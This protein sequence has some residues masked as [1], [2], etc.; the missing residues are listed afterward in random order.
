[1]IPYLFNPENDALDCILNHLYSKSLSDVIKK[2]LE[3]EEANFTE[4]LSAEIKKR[5]RIVIGK[6]VNKL[7]SK[8]DDEEC[9][10]ATSILTELVETNDYFSILKQKPTIQR[11]SELAFDI[12]EG[13]S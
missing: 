9:F 6:L 2:A 11:L 10:N 7:G 1:M 8:F 12:E 4:D 5:K 3:V 13:T